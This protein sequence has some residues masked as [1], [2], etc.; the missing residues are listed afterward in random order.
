MWANFLQNISLISQQMISHSLSIKQILFSEKCI[1][2]RKCSITKMGMLKNCLVLKRCARRS[3][4]FLWGHLGWPTQNP[5][6]VYSPLRGGGG[7][8]VQPWFLGEHNFEIWVCH[9]GQDMYKQFEGRFESICTTL[10]CEALEQKRCPKTK[11]MRA[12]HFSVF[13]CQNWMKN[14]QVMTMRFDQNKIWRPFTQ[15]SAVSNK[16]E[17]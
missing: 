7:G 4:N 5:V 11:A 1:Q 3:L 6:L 17:I 2:T 10:P 13:V 8:G 15:N 12:C 16:Y 9:D 14:G